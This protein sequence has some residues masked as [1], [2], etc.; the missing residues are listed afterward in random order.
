MLPLFPGISSLDC[1][2]SQDQPEKKIGLSIAFLDSTY[3]IDKKLCKEHG[4]TSLLVPVFLDNFDL[5]I[6]FS[7]Y[8]E[9]ISKQC[10]FLISCVMPFYDEVYLLKPVFTQESYFRLQERSIFFM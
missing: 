3:S 10:F 9:T 4:S 8:F 1:R 2:G 7:S 5:E 6:K